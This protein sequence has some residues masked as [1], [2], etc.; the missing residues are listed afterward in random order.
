MARG[1]GGGGLDPRYRGSFFWARGCFP[2]TSL[3]D[4]TCAIR[5]Q[6]DKSTSLANRVYLYRRNTRRDLV[7]RSA[8]LV[9]LRCSHD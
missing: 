6:V 1:G 9:V 7:T 2:K 4:F 5:K 8:R 3:L